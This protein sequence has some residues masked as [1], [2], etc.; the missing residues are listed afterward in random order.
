ML[1]TTVAPLDT[2]SGTTWSSQCSM[3]GP[4]NPT[5]LSMPCAVGCKRGA[6]LPSHANAASDL[7]TSAPIDARSNAPASSTPYP[8]V[9]DAVMTGEAN[10]TVPI[11][12]R[13]VDRRGAR[14]RQ[15]AAGEPHGIRP[16]A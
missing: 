12:D 1:A 13:Q 8:A 2:R 15:P 16:S 9:P 3:P 11:R 10:S 14:A 7:V 4:C 6:G 5:A